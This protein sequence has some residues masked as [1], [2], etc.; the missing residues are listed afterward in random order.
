MSV[1]IL[2]IGSIGAYRIS[3]AVQSLFAVAAFR[4]KL[5]SILAVMSCE[6]S[7]RSA[8]WLQRAEAES[9]SAPSAQPLL[10]LPRSSTAAPVESLPR[11]STAPAHSLPPSSTAAA[12]ASES[13]A[14]W[15]ATQGDTTEQPKKFKKL[16]VVHG[17]VIIE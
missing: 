15:P 1:A 14:G 7:P 5:G 10:S 9:Q 4:S 6:W 12:E 2:A 16:K 17:V 11:S 8:A 3:A 13:G